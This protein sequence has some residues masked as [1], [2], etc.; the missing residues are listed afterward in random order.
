M[1]SGYTQ[2]RLYSSAHIKRLEQKE[3]VCG[4][5]R[6]NEKYFKIS[7]KSIPNFSFTEFNS[8]L[9]AVGATIL[10]HSKIVLLQ[11][12]EFLLKH[13]DGKEIVP[14]VEGCS[15]PGCIGVIASGPSS[16]SV[17]LRS[18]TSNTLYLSEAPGP[19]LSVFV[20]YLWQGL[21]NQ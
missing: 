20:Q 19:C 10:S 17:V 2:E 3:N 11:C 1:N 6:L 18:G 4:Y 16:T 9:L 14:S 15:G 5:E 12:I 13:L 8:P 21:R 7:L